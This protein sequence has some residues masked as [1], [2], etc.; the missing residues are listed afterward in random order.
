VATWIALVSLLA[1]HLAT[2]Y[3][4][5]SCVAMRTLNRQRTNIVVSWFQ[6]TGI[7]L[8]PKE[9]SLRERV[10]ETSGILRWGQ[11]AVLGFA[12]VGVPF[13]T[14]LTSVDHVQEL[15]NVFRMQKY[16][17]WPTKGGRGGLP[18]VLICLKAGACANDQLKAWS[19]ALI[20]A[21]ELATAKKGHNDGG[22]YEKKLGIVRATMD[23][24]DRTFPG[25]AERLVEMGW[26]VDT[27]CIETSSG[28]RIS[29]LNPDDFSPAVGTDDDDSVVH[30]TDP[31][32]LERKKVV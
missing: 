32:Y 24:M 12:D 21:K 10:L 22:G 14:M 27:A 4:A 13:A 7:V 31:A 17:L 26:D 2:N 30:T 9:V 18:R 6:E 3:K 16:L 15:A 23:E 28:F 25:F 29:I 5:V 19:H 1:V 8:T 11:Y 20:V